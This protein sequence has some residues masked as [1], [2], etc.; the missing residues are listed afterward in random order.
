MDQELTQQ[1]LKG[2]LRGELTKRGMTY[3]YLVRGLR[4]IGIKETEANLRNKISRGTFSAAFFFECLAA[5][6]VQNVRV[7][8]LDLHDQPPVD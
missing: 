6:G 1:W 7:D 2:I 5:I 8:L 3:A 4:D